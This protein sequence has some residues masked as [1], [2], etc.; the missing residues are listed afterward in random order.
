MQHLLDKIILKQLQFYGFHGLFPEEKKL[1]QRFLIDVDLYASLR[2]AGETDDMYDSIDY[3][4]AYETIK[5]IVEGDS[6]NLIEA[7]ASDIAAS[8]FTAFDLLEAC[9]VKVTKPDPPIPGQ[10]E[11]VAV[12][13]HR[14]RNQ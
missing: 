6:K 3:G 5:Q 8:L 1:G 2:K 13:I 14:K 10:Y 12:E 11:A 7:V 9:Q 4:K